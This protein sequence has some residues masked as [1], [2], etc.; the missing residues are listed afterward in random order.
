MD[1]RCALAIAAIARN[2]FKPS[3]RTWLSLCEVAKAYEVPYQ[4]VTA[5]FNG[6]QTRKEAHAHQS[7]LTPAAEEALVDWIQEMGRRGIPLHPST[8]ALHANAI[9]G[10]H[11][12]EHW[13]ARYRRRHPD[14]KAKWTRTPVMP[15]K[16]SSVVKTLSENLPISVYG[17]RHLILDGHNSHTTYCF[18]SFTE[19][20]RIIRT[21]PQHYHPS[22]TTATVP[23]F[24]DHTPVHSTTSTPSPLAAP[25]YTLSANTPFS[26][27]SP[28]PTPSSSSAGSAQFSSALV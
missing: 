23:T 22:C 13:V 11:I 14:L 8:V 12:G 9:S 24:L 27:V 3:G 4:R 7:H 20:H 17:Y 6:W 26:S 2:G 5:R 16:F 28:V 1:E 10:T 15:G 25:V 18:C 19:Q 21:C